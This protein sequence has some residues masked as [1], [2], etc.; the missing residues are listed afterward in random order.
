MLFIIIKRIFEV[1]SMVVFISICL[2]AFKG[3]TC[4]EVSTVSAVQAASLLRKRARLV[5][6]RGVFWTNP[7]STGISV[8]IYYVCCSLSKDC[9]DWDTAPYA[10]VNLGLSSL[11]NILLSYNYNIKR[12]CSRCNTNLW[13]IWTEK[14]PT[15]SLI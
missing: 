8:L 15:H 1:D 12:Y 2:L 5:L 3:C 10:A 7:P 13:I 4:R 6:G 9:Y 14:S 11:F